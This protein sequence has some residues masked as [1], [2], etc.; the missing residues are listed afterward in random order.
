MQDKGITKEMIIKKNPLR[1]RK[2]EEKQ[3]IFRD[4]ALFSLFFLFLLQFTQ[5]KGRYDTRG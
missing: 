5:T 2:N 4:S 3:I 1:K